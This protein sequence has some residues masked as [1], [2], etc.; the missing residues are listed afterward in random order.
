M[1]F[2]IERF[3]STLKHCIGDILL[4]E[5]DDPKLKFV[6]LLEVNVS[7]DLK[8]ANI[9]VSSTNSDCDDFLI[10]LNNAKGL[11]KKLLV[12]KMY[13]KYVPEIIFIT[14]QFLDIEKKVNN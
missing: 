1:S 10:Q 6:T 14:D 8:K 12:K 11:I 13:L 9:Y 2:R 4:N 5:I 7:K 3:S